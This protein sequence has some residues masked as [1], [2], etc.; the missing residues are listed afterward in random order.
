MHRRGN[1]IVPRR[2]VLAGVAGG[3]QLNFINFEQSK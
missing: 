3:S 1:V 2:V